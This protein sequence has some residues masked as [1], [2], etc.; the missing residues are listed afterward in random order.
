MA[1]RATAFGL[2]VESETHL[3]LLDG[4]AAKPTGRLLGVSVRGG[5]EPRWPARPT[6][7]CDDYQPDGSLIYQIE[8]HREVGYLISG[9]DYGAHLLSL[10]GQQLRCDP[11]GLPDGGWQRLL[12]AQV[13]PFAALLQGL[14]VF[15]AS[16]IV[17]RAR[18]VAFLGR[19]RAGKTSIAMELCRRGAAFLADDVVALECCDGQL[20]AHPGTPVAGVEQLRTDSTDATDEVMHEEVIAV[21]A[22]ERLVRVSGAAEPVRLAAL[23]FLDRRVD[24]PEHPRFEADPN[25]QMLL[26]ATF[27]FVLATPERLRGLLEVCALAAQAR[28]E[29]IVCGPRTSVSELGDAVELRLGGST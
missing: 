19:S 12:I 15:H 16:A 27:N 22:R 28:V 1:V 25:T 10:D 8:T 21:N 26:S 14:E 23:F 4:A 3:A 13:L 5:V 7:M 2:D 9:P 18:G 6:L 24:G 11:R 29:R 17:W 20:L